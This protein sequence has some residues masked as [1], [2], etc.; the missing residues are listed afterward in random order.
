M[1]TLSLL[2]LNDRA[3]KRAI[4]CAFALAIGS[5]GVS[6]AGELLIERTLLPDSAPSSFA[7][8][9][10]N[11]VNFCYDVVRG[12]VSYVWQGGFAD[13]TSV[14]P[15]AGKS[16]SPIKLLGEIVYRET[17]YSP[18]RRGDPQRSVELHFKGYRLKGDAIEFLYEID[19]RRISE[20]VRATAEGDGLI[21]RFRIE[22]AATGESWWYVPGPTTGGTVS[23]PGARRD[24]DGFQFN[25][26]QGLTL[27]VQ[28]GK[29]T[30]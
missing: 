19:R 23:A 9:F 27:E 17:S 28:F 4:P 10:P 12:G 20:E 8:G 22:G 26:E 11:G 6:R 5:A 29:A 16:I 21:R 30:S 14:R 2:R 15:N 7:I 13:V 24:A 25:A 18:L 3:W 1:V